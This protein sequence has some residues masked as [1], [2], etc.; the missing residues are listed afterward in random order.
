MGREIEAAAQHTPRTPGDVVLEV[1]RLSLP[2]PGH[3]R[4]WRLEEINFTLRRGEVLGIA[5]LLER[6]GRN[7]SN[8]SLA[9]APYRRRR[10][11]RRGKSVKISPSRGSS[12]SGT[13]ACHRRPQDAG[14]VRQTRRGVDITLCDSKG[15][16]QGGLLNPW[17]EAELAERMVA[18]LAVKTAG[19]IAPITALSGGN[20]QTVHSRP[21]AA[22]SPANSAAR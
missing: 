3:A 12:R 10:N 16:S 18:Q 13:R 7:S 1:R 15:A 6:G 5:G 22:D 9:P 14:A 11:L 8:V 21:L 4:R 19:S 17:R 2:W 20:Q